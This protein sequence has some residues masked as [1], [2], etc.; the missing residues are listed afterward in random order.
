MGCTVADVGRVTSLTSLAS[1]PTSPCGA[2]CP[3]GSLVVARSCAW[4]SWTWRNGLL[5]GTGR[6]IPEVVLVSAFGGLLS[7]VLG[8]VATALIF[9]DTPENCCG[10][11]VGLFNQIGD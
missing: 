1:L 3:T 9:D 2:N 5:T 8:P 6:S 10:E 11:I 4:N 7:T